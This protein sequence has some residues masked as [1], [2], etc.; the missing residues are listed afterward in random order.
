MLVTDVV[1]G[2]LSWVELLGAS[3]GSL[4]GALWY[5]DRQ[6]GAFRLVPAQGSLSPV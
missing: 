3:L 2:H 4:R 1:Q 5:S 6:G